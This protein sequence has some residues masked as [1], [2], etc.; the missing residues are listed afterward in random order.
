[1]LGNYKIGHKLIASFCVVALISLLVGGIGLWG[2]SKL[3]AHIVALANHRLPSIDA[4]RQVETQI[5]RVR[6]AQRTL[7]SPDLSDEDFK[8]QFENIADVRDKYKQVLATYEA[9]PAPPRRGASSE[10]LHVGA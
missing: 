3:R 1:M 4:L 10:G 7:L 6:V 5:E 2:L 9:L 8:R